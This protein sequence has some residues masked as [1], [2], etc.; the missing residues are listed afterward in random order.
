MIQVWLS[1]TIPAPDATT[2]DISWKEAI[3]HSLDKN[4]GLELG[5]QACWSAI[6]LR[7]EFQPC[8]NTWATWSS[9]QLPFAAAA[10]SRR[11]TGPESMT[12]Q[13]ESSSCRFH[14]EGFSRS[15]TRLWKEQRSRSIGIY[16]I[17]YE[18][19]QPEISKVCSNSFTHH[20]HSIAFIS[21]WCLRWKGKPQ[22]LPKPPGCVVY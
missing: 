8:V 3:R 13:S 16:I 15:F 11:F 14:L 2:I 1:C 4:P 6:W 18:W 22:A 17:V 12:C 21:S 10:A 20:V 9:E 19:Q 7:P 5:L